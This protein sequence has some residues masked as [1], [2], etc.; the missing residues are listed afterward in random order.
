MMV[1]SISKVA[2]RAPKGTRSLIEVK[3][4][5]ANKPE[6]LGT[7]DKVYEF[8]KQRDNQLINKLEKEQI[9]KITQPV[10]EAQISEKPIKNSSV[11]IFFSLITGV[12]LGIL[13]ALVRKAYIQHSERVLFSN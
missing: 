9:I 8:I 5:D 12:M 4:S 2:A 3:T 1:S 6:I 10:G 7:L 13:I 11:I